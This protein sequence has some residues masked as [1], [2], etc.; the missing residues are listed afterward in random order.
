MLTRTYLRGSLF[1]RE[2]TNVTSLVQHKR[3][4]HVAVTSR[5]TMTGR[6]VSST[7]L[8][9]RMEAG[10]CRQQSMDDVEYFFGRSTRHDGMQSCVGHFHGHE[11]DVIA[12]IAG[13]VV[14]HAYIQA[15]SKASHTKTVISRSAMRH[16]K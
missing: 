10:A 1:E 2:K 9:Y 11:A 5:T 16:V 13:T 12:V 7:Q 6:H 8:Q 15:K 3:A 14:I 4:F